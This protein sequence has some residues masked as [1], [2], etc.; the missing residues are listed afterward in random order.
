MTPL[1]HKIVRELTLPVKD[2]SFIDRCGLLNLMCDVHCFEVT[3]VLDL[4]CKI[5]G[6]MVRSDKPVNVLGFLPAP[7]TWLELKINSEKIERSGVLLVGSGERTSAYWAVEGKKRGFGS[8][9]FIG[10]LLLGPRTL[11]GTFPDVIKS[12]P[13]L[14]GERDWLLGIYGFLALINSPHIIGRRQHEPHRGLERALLREQKAIGKFPLRAWTEIRLECGP[15]KSMSDYEGYGGH[16]SGRR[17]LHFCRAHL[18]IRNGQA[19]FVKAHYRGDASLGIKQTR[20]RAV[21]PA[22]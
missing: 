11:R 12:V 9:D 1:A 8:S 16:L 13:G 18:R 4:A 7:K 22:N 15:P 6:D 3:E 17:C 5:A 20:Y 21:P 10:T 14:S 19:E 2:R